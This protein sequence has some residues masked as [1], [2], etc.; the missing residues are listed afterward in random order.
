MGKDNYID[1]IYFK[2]N[3]ISL[4]MQG[5]VIEE[6]YNIKVCDG[7]VNNGILLILGNTSHVF[8]WSPQKIH[9]IVLTKYKDYE[10]CFS[11]KEKI[12]L[13]FVQDV[14]ETIKELLIKYKQQI[15]NYCDLYDVKNPIHLG[16]DEYIQYEATTIISEN[17]STFVSERDN[18]KIKPRV[19]N[20]GFF[21][22]E[23]TGKF[24]I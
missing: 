14:L 18:F 13:Y 17:M 1:D 5:N 6:L 3:F 8:S 7:G 19:F 21:S 2:R 23:T 4:D 9:H 11:T 20:P 12:I 10:S 22:I 24:S 16:Y 15:L